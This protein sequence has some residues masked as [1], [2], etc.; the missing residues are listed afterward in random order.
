MD[1]MDSMDYPHINMAPLK[2]G[3]RIFTTS[4]N[5]ARLLQSFDQLSAVLHQ[6]I[7]PAVTRPW[8]PWRPG[9]GFLYQQISS[10]F[11]SHKNETFNE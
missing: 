10:D 2:Q 8:R 4:G 5:S 7:A 1:S 6:F 11:W 3:R 9:G